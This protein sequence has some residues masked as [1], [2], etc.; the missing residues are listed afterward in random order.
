MRSFRG[1]ELNGN[2]SLDTWNRDS[3]GDARRCLGRHLGGS[4]SQTG[5]VCRGPGLAHVHTHVPCL[6]GPLN[7][8]NFLSSPPLRTECSLSV[9]FEMSMCSA[10]KSL[11]H[12]LSEGRQGPSSSASR[13]WPG[14]GEDGGFVCW[15]V[16]GLHPLS[17]ANS[18]LWGGPSSV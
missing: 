5:V 11:S 6:F 12:H 15:P 8:F 9:H 3:P 7:H 13:T 10:P 16:H 2:F 18:F 17:M 4:G 14:K 1:T